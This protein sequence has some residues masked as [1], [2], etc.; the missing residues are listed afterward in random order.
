MTVTGGSIRA[1]P[2][3]S[4]RMFVADA[5][6]KTGETVP[7]HALAA[8]VDGLLA[9]DPGT[10]TDDELADAMVALRRLQARLAAAV[11][12]AT[13][14]FDARQVYATDGSRSAADWISARTRQPRSEVRAEVRLGRR[15][16]VMPLTRA[17]LRAGDIGV[18]HAHKLSGLAAN[19]RTAAHFPDG[20][21]LLVANA[22]SMR[23][24]DFERTADHWRDAADPDGPERR[25]GR[26]HDLRRVDLH[27]GLG[28]VGLLSGH[29]TELANATVGGALER[30]E[31]ELFAAD[32][33]A[34]RAE[35]GDAAT[36]AHLARTG[37]QRRHDALVEMALRAMTAPK[38]GK[39]PAPLITVMVGYETFAG[40]VCQLA[41]G[42]VIAPG[43]VV[44]LLGQHDTLIERVVF[45]GPNRVTD[46]SS[47]RTFR[48]VMRRVLEVKHPRC[49]HDTCHIPADQC[50]GD[51]ILAWSHGGL[52]TQD[53]GQLQCG[54]HNRWRHRHPDQDPTA[55]GASTGPERW[56]VET[57]G[58][59]LLAG[60]L[61]SRR[62]RSRPRP[63]LTTV[64]GWRPITCR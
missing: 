9:V 18:A 46:I 24:D 20:E 25:R 62:Q 59:R 15:L 63:D 49:T 29:L 8:V 12:E 39:R 31:Q 44:E 38:H 10:L 2:L 5:T 26:D 33:A 58:E 56:H 57:A 47:A 41:R 16:R 55:V 50:Q 36:A 22:R 64:Q 28:G 3:A 53:N 37:A 43:T 23:F 4:E 40:R 42:T 21:P 54:H 34:A 6:G 32:W 17:A 19:P 45:D 27:T 52:T 1:A 51:H 30:I 13:A 11:V 7:V 14:V 61:A 35:H 48:G 60:H